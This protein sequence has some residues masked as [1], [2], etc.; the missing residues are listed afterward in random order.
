MGQQMLCVLTSGV[1]EKVADDT[2]FAKF[3]NRSLLRFMK[4]DW[5]DELDPE[6][7]KVNDENSARLEAGEWYGTVLASYLFKA[8]EPSYDD[9]WIMRNTADTDGTVAITILFP[10]EY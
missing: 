10:G 4:R 6:S 7:W 9:I 2:D 5:G 3:V 1:Q 8:N